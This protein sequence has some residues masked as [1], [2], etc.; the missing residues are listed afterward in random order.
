M[1]SCSL[2]LAIVPPATVAA[3]GRFTDDDGSQVRERDQARVAARRDARLHDS[4]H[5]CPKTV[6]TKGK[7]AVY[8]ARALHLKA[9]VTT[10]FRDVPSR[11]WPRV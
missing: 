3:A 10:K 2:L 7:M 1:R 5:F 4:N 11:L 9:T 6:V 8:L